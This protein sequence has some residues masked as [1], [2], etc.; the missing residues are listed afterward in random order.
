MLKR[1]DTLVIATHNPDK[2]REIAG[3][4]APFGLKTRSAAALGLPE[5]DETGATLAVNARLKAVAAA[6][7][8]GWPALADDSGLVV[9]ALGGEPGVHSARWAGADRDYTRAMRDLEKKL[10]ACGATTPAKRRA[11]F[12]SVV[13]LASPEGISQTF[14]GEVTG[15]LVWPPRGEGGFGYDP[16]FQPDGHD[17]TF[18]EMSVADKQAL[19]HRARAL[20]AFAGAS[21]GPDRGR[22]Q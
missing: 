12:I 3:L 16:M 18:G 14:R 9:A 4:L 8:S 21:L 19:S 10:V 17:R 1:G 11:G 5:P 2:L 15:T 6:I 7:A 20:A 13:C 22:R